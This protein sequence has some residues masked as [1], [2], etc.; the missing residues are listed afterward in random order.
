M[1]EYKNRMRILKKDNHKGKGLYIEYI[2]QRQEEKKR[3]KAIYTMSYNN[4]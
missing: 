3:E 2:N 1:R 4:K